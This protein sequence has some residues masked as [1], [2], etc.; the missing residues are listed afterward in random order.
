MGVVLSIWLDCLGS[1]FITV[2]FVGES[3]WKDSFIEEVYIS[4]RFV[5]QGVYTDVSNG[6]KI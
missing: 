5:V 6:H 1:N 3:A 2:W 4:R